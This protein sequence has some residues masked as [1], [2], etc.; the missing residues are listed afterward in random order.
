MRVRETHQTESKKK[1]T[2]KK[3][4]KKKGAMMEKWKE[5]NITKHNK[6]A[7]VRERE[8]ERVVLMMNKDD[9]SPVG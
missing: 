3:G 9:Y 2:T 8:R 5:I 1:T 4:K 7:R 6:R